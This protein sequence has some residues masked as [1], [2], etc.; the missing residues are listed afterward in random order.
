[1]TRKSMLVVLAML[2]SALPASAQSLGKTL[3]NGH[4]ARC[5]GI[6]GIGGEG[7]SLAVPVLRHAPND[8]ALRSVIAD[9][10]ESTEMPG[11]WMLGVNEIDAVARYVRSLSRVEAQEIPG[12]GARGRALYEGKGACSVCHIINGD[13]GT[14]GP[15]LSTVGLTRGA[16]HLRQSLVQPGEV[17]PSR[18]VVVRA[19]TSDGDELTG[20]RVNEDSFTVQVRDDTGRFYSLDKFALASFEKNLGESLMPSY[21]SDLTSDELDDIVAYLA[22]LKGE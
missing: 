3:F 13:G 19:V 2:A 5:H 22:S 11:N 8:D 14:I 20:V 21:A 10:I 12:D 6:D 17:V 7:P 16:S 18:F 4:C 1:M 9:G 15:D